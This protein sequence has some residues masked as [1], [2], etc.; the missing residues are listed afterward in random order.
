MS[1]VAA[2]SART[3]LLAPL[4]GASRPVL[5]P[6]I[7]NGGPPLADRSPA[8]KLLVR[9]WRCP[10]SGRSPAQESERVPLGRQLVRVLAPGD[11]LELF[12]GMQVSRARNRPRG[13]VANPASVIGDAPT[14]AMRAVGW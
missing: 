14:M 8:G 2:N 10:D 1:G 9:M 3:G 6:R 11:M 4:S 7:G 12:P 5:A 13:G